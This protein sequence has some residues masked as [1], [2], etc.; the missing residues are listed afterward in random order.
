MQFWENTLEN[1]RKVL[2]IPNITNSRNIETDSFIDVLINHI[3]KLGDEFYWHV[4]VPAAVKRLSALPNV[5]QHIIDMSGNMV[6]MRNNL[7]LDIIKLLSFKYDLEYDVIYSHLPDWPVGR[8]A[9]TPIIGYAHWWEMTSC[10]GISNMN[11]WLNFEQE[12]LGAL[13]MNRLFINTL[14]QKQAVL[15][16]AQRYFNDNIIKRLDEIIQPFYLTTN[17]EDIADDAKFG[18]EKL[19]VFPH[20]VTE[21]K[22]WPKLYAFLK[23]YREWRQDFKVWIPQAK[24]DNKAFEENWILTDSKPKSEYLETLRHC[25][26]CITPTQSH[27]GWSLASTDAMSKGCPVLFG[28]CGN[29]KEIYPNGLFYST[30][31]ELAALLDKLLDDNEY[32]WAEGKKSLDRAIELTQSNGYSELKDLLLNNNLKPINYKDI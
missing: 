25:R 29:Y 9:Q 30:N 11:R 20:R 28:E 1:K 16:E 27:H 6:W 26:V 31:P 2:V 21:Y 5:Q 3:Q 15:K 7:P 8:Y 18:N 12:V 23:K 32:Q 24:N 4:P 19:I 10:N 14:E 22:G 13:Q 17:P